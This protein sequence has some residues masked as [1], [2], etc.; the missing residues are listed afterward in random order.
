MFFFTR[1]QE[2]ECFLG[3]GQ[4]K[5]KHWFSRPKKGIN[6][7]VYLIQTLCHMLSMSNLSQVCSTEAE[8]ISCGGLTA[9]NLLI[10][11]KH[12]CQAAKQSQLINES[13]KQVLRSN[14]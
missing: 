1:W 10:N 2:T 3:S 7:A 9:L 6:A 11:Y 14:Y 13:I 8:L 4:K 5:D 12:A